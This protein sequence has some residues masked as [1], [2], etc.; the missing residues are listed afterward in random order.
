MSFLNKKY[1]FMSFSLKK[2]MICCFFV[3]KSRRFASFSCTKLILFVFF[4]QK[5]TICGFSYKKVMVC[6]FS[7]DKWIIVIESLT[8][9]SAVIYWRYFICS[10]ANIFEDLKDSLVWLLSLHIST[11]NGCCLFP[12]PPPVLACRRIRGSPISGDFRGAFSAWLFGCP[13]DCFSPRT[14]TVPL[15]S[16]VEMKHRSGGHF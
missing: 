13:L 9:S 7:W 4:F 11:L 15:M 16:Y 2:I 8:I 3:R 10:T 14:C 5:V 6:V 12:P 1:G